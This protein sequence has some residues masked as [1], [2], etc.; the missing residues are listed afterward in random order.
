MV[1]ILL[2]ANRTSFSIAS[3]LLISLKGLQTV[4]MEDMRA[5]KD[6][7]LLLKMKILEAN[8]AGVILL[9]LCSVHVDLLNIFPLGDSQW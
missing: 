2:S 3:R 5:A 8:W 4:S 6:F 7:L 1:V 9:L